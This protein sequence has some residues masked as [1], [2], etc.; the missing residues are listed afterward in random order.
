[1]D[2]VGYLT[3]SQKEGLISLL[4]KQESGG[5]FKDPVYLKNWRPITLQ[6]Y[7][8]KI[9]AKCIAI[10]QKNVLTDL[11]HQDQSGF[12]HGRNIGNNIR[13][14]LDITENYDLEDKKA[15]IFV[16]DLEKA[17]DQISLDFIYKSLAFFN[18]G[19]SLLNWVK[20]LYNG[21]IC[22]IINNGNIS[23]VIPLLRG[24]K[25]GCPL[26]PYLFIIAMEILAIN[27]RMENNIE[28]LTVNNTETKISM[29]ADDTS[30]LFSPKPQCLHKLI[31]LLDIFSQQ[32]G[33]K[34]NYDKCK[35]LRI[36]S[37][38]RTDY[39]LKCQVSVGWTDGPVSVLGIVIPENLEELCTLNYN[40]KLK[41]IDKII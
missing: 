5:Q 21:A 20:T 22:R 7:D 41:K 8:A 9:L 15:L 16:A 40:N 29:Y 32:S 19:S 11:I 17:F 35:I 36:G 33:L 24:V 1:M 27:V 28:G 4:L 13:R 34:L 23:E 39:K 38:K 2:K 26:S 30:F 14:L 12:L 18:F 31:S 25:Q 37:L 10:R 6:C 3:D